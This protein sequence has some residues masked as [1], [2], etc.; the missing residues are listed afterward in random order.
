M[1]RPIGAERF[2]IEQPAIRIR[3]NER[4]RKFQLRAVWKRPLKAVRSARLV[5]AP[6]HWRIALIE[7]DAR[8]RARHPVIEAESRPSVWRK[9]SL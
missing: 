4:A 9:D 6:N 5:D 7:G 8:E 1:R 2:P 3:K